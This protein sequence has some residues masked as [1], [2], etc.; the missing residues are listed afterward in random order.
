MI[1]FR[2]TDC[3]LAVSAIACLLFVFMPAVRAAENAGGWLEPKFHDLPAESRRALGPLFF[4]HGDET[5]AR[6]ELE[7]AKVAEGGNG[8]FTTESRPHTDWL[9]PGWFRD[10]GI[11]L[12]AAKKHHLKMWIFDEKWFPSQAIG[13]RVPPQFAAK[14]LAAAASEVVGPRAWQADGYAG[15][16][17][18]GAVAGRTAADGK[19]DGDSLVDL[20]PFV[21]DGRV[22]WDVPAGQVED[23]PLRPRAG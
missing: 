2:K 5:R 4:L 21:R 14:T 12:E 13:G 1:R 22:A 3:L 23:H 11:C 6:L 16:R 8:C 17:Y 18:I 19:I 15:P 20:A 7:V 9:G 10:L